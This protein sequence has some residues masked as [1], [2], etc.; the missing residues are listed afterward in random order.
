MQAPSQSSFGHRY[1]WEASR[2]KQALPGC[3]FSVSRRPR[4]GKSVDLVNGR[5]T[6]LSPTNEAP[7]KQA[8]ERQGATDPTFAGRPSASVVGDPGKPRTEAEKSIEAIRKLGGRLAAA[9]IT[10]PSRW[11]SMPAKSPMPTLFI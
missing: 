5:L 8:V 7:K 11:I 2:L 9:I 10:D 6:L 1:S 4:N 3:R